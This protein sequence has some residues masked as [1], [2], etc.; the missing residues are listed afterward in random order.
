MREAADGSRDSRWMGALRE[1]LERRSLGFLL[2]V[3]LLP[4]AVAV[5]VVGAYGL[6]A[7][8][9]T[10]ERLDHVYHVDMQ[11]SMD[12]KEGQVQLVRLGRALRQLALAA[13]RTGQQKALGLMTEAQTEL[14]K[15]VAD[16]RRRTPGREGLE[17]LQ[18]FDRH[19]LLYRHQLD[20]LLVLVR[21]GRFVELAEA[22]QRDELLATADAA[23]AELEGVAALKQADA[24]QLAT[25]AS[26]HARRS[27]QTIVLLVLS[28]TLLGI[29]AAWLTIRSIRRPAA[30]LRHHVESLTA[31]RFDAVVPYTGYDND[32]GDLARTIDTLQAG[33]REIAWQSRVKTEVAE[34]STALQT[35]GDPAELGRRFLSRVAPAMG[36]GRASFYL[37][38]DE[39][40]RL[41]LLVGYALDPDAPAPATIPFGAGL[42]GQCALE[43]RMLRIADAPAGYAR[44]GSSLGSADARALL[45]V[46]LQRGDRLLGVLEFAGFGAFD[47]QALAL[48]DAALPTLA[49]SL[50]IAQRSAS[51]RHL[52]DA[53][54]EQ[55]LRLE[56]QAAELDAQRRRLEAT[57]AWYRGIIESAPDGMLVIDADGRIAI[58]NAQLA[59]MF[60]YPDGSL[61]GQPVEVLVPASSRPVHAGLRAGYLRDGRPRQMGGGEVDLRGRRADGS[62]FAVEISLAQLPASPER[63]GFVCASVR[64]ITE[65]RRTE[66]VL[67]EQR[68]ELQNILERSP[69][70][71]AFATGGQ[72]H[73][74]NPKFQQ[75]FGLDKGADGGDIYAER[76]Q[77]DALLER[78]AAEGFVHD[79]ELRLLAA[80][81]ALRDYLATFVRMTHEGRDG[82]MGWLI[83]ITERKAA[84]TAMREAKEI[85][86]EATRAKSDF[87]ANMSHEIRTPM[88]AIIGMSHLALQT[89][90]EPRQRNYVEKVHRAAENLLG[91][92]NDILDFSKIEA[93]KLSL[94]RTD[95]RLEDVMDQLA[96]VVGMKAED[97]ALELLFT[98]DPEVPTALVG[99]PLRLGQVLVNLASNA[100]KFTERG[101]VVVAVR[102]AAREA[103]GVELHFAVRDTGI[104]IDAAQCG[105]LFR[106][107]SQADS[108]ITRR[109]GGT[110]L[111]LA[112]CKDLVALMDGRIW[113]D[114]TPGVGS[115]FQFHARFGV[116]ARPAPRQPVRRELLLGVRALVVD[117]NAAAREILAGM[118]QQH[119][120]EADVARDGE[121]ALE[122]ARSGQQRG[123]PYDVV[124]MDWKMPVMDGVETAA[125]LHD[126]LQ[127]DM[128]SI[129]MVTAF[130]RE[131]ALAAAEQR[132]VRLQS[133]LTK[134]VTA[135][136]LLRAI[137]EAL[138]RSV[139]LDEAVAEPGHDHEGALAALRG[140]RVL[141]V[142]D[143]DLN[144]EL[145]GELLQ[146][147]GIA[148]AVA[149]NGR[150]ALDLL[151]RDDRFDGVLMDC[152]MP[153]MDGYAATRAIRADPRWARLPVIA[154]TANVMEGAS[155]RERAAGMD[156]RIAKPLDLRSMF[157]TMARWIRP[158]SGAPAAPPTEAAPIPPSS[159]PALAGID[160]DRGLATSGGDPGLYRRLLRRFAAGQAD[161]GDRFR[162]ALQSADPE[163]ATRAAHTLKATAGNIGARDVQAAAGALEQASLEGRDPAVLAPWLHTVE[164]ALAGVLAGLAAAGEDSTGGAVPEAATAT[165]E[166][167]GLVRRLR[168]LLEADDSAAAE[169]ADPLAA[170]ARGTPWGP[171]LQRAARAAAAF[172]FDAAL[173]A[174][175]EIDERPA[176][177]SNQTERAR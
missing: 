5:F 98:I 95:F 133:V 111:G 90:M 74:A 171:A 159:L 24:A 82:T 42:V 166:L 114:S 19:Y 46:P 136:G 96:S 123:L 107:F 51:T 140:A 110:G 75:A 126:R 56:A 16:L 165:P 139:A 66:A 131:D 146:R 15:T 142:E 161:F 70:A 79:I 10:A 113:V 53:T 47:G 130:G 48:L 60:G 59:R 49:M 93:G 73:Y 141:L 174:L 23:A 3:S 150:E 87:L 27:T 43:R 54:R 162:A 7:T 108:S 156:D 148:F 155:T 81:G 44:L 117:D 97:K 92:I 120:L 11:A 55:A 137:A 105:Q 14:D 109:Y 145:A 153:V 72:F 147:A 169:L 33:A 68:V 31:G 88:N 168:T 61:V 100:V 101:E 85:A 89:A 78:I 91:I 158:R 175:T 99:D 18:A 143:N 76:A 104:G 106:S 25:Q 63:T 39:A 62:E 112:I 138:G 8:R 65:R 125:R 17:R 57:E 22:V 102:L 26:E 157:V 149:G 173:A 86:E 37:A 160:V 21:E 52:L 170:R 172:D 69:I 128:P 103:D 116:Q 36:A 58:A 83:D 32:V 6:Y 45:L 132:R 135:A 129:I 154:M 115:T 71:I 122:M 121:Q 1:R 35:A 2:V 163:A 124:L 40:A 30:R 38:D 20:D 134:P 151:A 84:E 4:L 80:G 119:G 64:D 50:E 12:A 167:A 144:Q 77:R 41:Q 13:D 164:Q 176:P 67:A 127:H 118:A 9:S 34:L 152:Q 28:T 177:G 94:E 29:V